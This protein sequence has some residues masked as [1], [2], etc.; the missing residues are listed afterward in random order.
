MPPRITLLIAFALLS[1]FADHAHGQVNSP[2]GKRY[3]RSGFELLPNGYQRE[4]VFF[5]VKFNEDYTC[6]IRYTQTGYTVGGEWN[7][8]DGGTT[9]RFRSP[10]KDYTVVP[11]F[12]P[13]GKTLFNNGTAALEYQGDR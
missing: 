11:N 7:L 13:Y 10:S 3:A 2:A 5:T 4:A 1:A 8:T 6:V 12:V 9:L